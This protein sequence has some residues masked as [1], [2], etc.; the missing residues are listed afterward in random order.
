MNWRSTRAIASAIILTLGA[1]RVSYAQESPSIAE[2]KSILHEASALIPLIE[3]PLHRS[4]IAANIASQ[5]ARAGDLDGALATLPVSGRD[6]EVGGIAYQLAAQGHLPIALQLVEATPD[7]QTRTR[8]RCQ[9]AQGLLKGCPLTSIKMPWTTSPQREPD[10][11]T[12]QV[13]SKSSMALIY[14]TTRGHSKSSYNS[15]L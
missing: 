6:R 14:Q 15:W 4:T 1:V 3:P 8:E 10:W 11:V 13:R 9:I 2:V 12:S 7:E 5:L